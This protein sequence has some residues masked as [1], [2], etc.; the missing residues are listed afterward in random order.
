[1][2]CMMH[3][4]RSSL[5]KLPLLK[6]IAKVGQ[7]LWNSAT[8]TWFSVMVSGKID[9]W[10][11][12]G[13]VCRTH[14]IEWIVRS[15]LPTTA[16]NIL[17]N[18]YTF[19]NRSRSLLRTMSTKKAATE[20]RDDEQSPRVFHVFRPPLH[21]LC[22]VRHWRLVR[23]IRRHASDAPPKHTFRCCRKTSSPENTWPM[24][25]PV[26]RPIGK[27]ASLATAQICLT[28]ASCCSFSQWLHSIDG[29]SFTS[30][31]QHRI[32]W[33]RYISATNTLLWIT[34]PE[35]TQFL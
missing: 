14:V 6:G 23:R 17:L 3:D 18:G 19:M 35:P 9:A 13:K 2:Q 7:S 29:L 12:S 20:R 11:W 16:A 24:C 25:N 26:N 28:Y 32:V 5:E 4:S 31:W 22:L 21:R 33:R 27:N 8:G 15:L 10:C 34:E 30:E 1:M